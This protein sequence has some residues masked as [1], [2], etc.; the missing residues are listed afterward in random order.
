MDRS[1][2]D[3]SKYSYKE[4]LGVRLHLDRDEFPE[5][6]KLVEALISEKE[7]QEGFLIEEDSSDDKVLLGILSGE[8]LILVLVG[9]AT[10]LGYS[11]F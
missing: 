11:I 7:K 9:I 4:L 3:Y 6:F 2:P 1:E 8:L 10:L 5:R